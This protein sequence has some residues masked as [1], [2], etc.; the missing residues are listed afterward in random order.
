MTSVT[1]MDSDH[2]SMLLYVDLLCIHYF[3]E[4]T[5][6]LTEYVAW[7]LCCRVGVVLRF[8]CELLLIVLSRNLW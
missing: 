4:T 8:L 6:E 1:V 5:T 7:S 2:N 3:F